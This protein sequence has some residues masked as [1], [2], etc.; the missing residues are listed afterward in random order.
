MVSSPNF[1]PPPN[2]QNLLIFFGQ[3]G[4]TTNHDF[5]PRKWSQVPILTTL[6]PNKAFLSHFAEVRGS[7]NI[8]MSFRWDLDAW[9]LGLT[10]NCIKTYQNDRGKPPTFL[11]TPG[12]LNPT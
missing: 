11:P 1:D 4:Q 6:P 12:A 9:D 7:E 10:K 3:G 8:L 5:S 2:K